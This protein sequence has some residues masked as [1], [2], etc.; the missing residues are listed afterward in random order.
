MHDWQSEVRARLAALRLIPEREAD[1]VDEIAQH[2]A[3]RYR[4]A[5]SGGASAEEA[6]RVALADFQAGNEL[7]QRIASLKQAHAPAVATAGASTGHLVADFA[8]DLR[9]AVRAFAKK[10]GFAATAVLTL[11]LGIGATT[12]IFSLVYGVL[13][14]P[15][16]FA[17]PQAL[18]SLRHYA[19]F[20]ETTQGPATYF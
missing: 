16:P 20:G 2:L 5:I 1:I 9:Y 12:A 13:L 3:E 6:T 15:L 4:E 14:K 10:P 7:A 19:N 18:V 11:A 8:Q 17:E